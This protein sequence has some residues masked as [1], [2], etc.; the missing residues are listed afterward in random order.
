MVALKTAKQ[1]LL[2][3]P[4]FEED[5][6]I[7]CSDSQA[8]LATPRGGQVAQTPPPPHPLGAAIWEYM[9]ALVAVGGRRI[10]HRRRAAIARLSWASSGASALSWALGKDSASTPVSSIFDG[11]PVRKLSPPEF[12]SSMGHM[13]PNS[14][15]PLDAEDQARVTVKR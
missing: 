4:S 3:H 6:I 13:K 8:S 1:H 10:H 11:T 15:E 12:P 5:P 9:M 7:I 14:A 2:E